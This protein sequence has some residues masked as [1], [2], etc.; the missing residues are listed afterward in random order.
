MEIDINQRFPKSTC[1]TRWFSAGK[2]ET[3]TFTD[4]DIPPISELLPHD[5][6][7]ILLDRV[8]CWNPKRLVAEVD[9][10]RR[11]LFSD[12]QGLTPSWL[13][14]EY[15]VQAMGALA[16]LKLIQE[17]EDVKIGFLLGVRNFK[18][19][20]AKFPNEGKLL[21]EVNEVLLDPETNLA[22]FDGTITQ[23]GTILCEGQIKAVMPEDPHQLLEK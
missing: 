5:P 14:I 9:C 18:A 4:M 16:G 15:L 19:M 8:V 11:N 6:P 3:N 23:D 13:G 7:M 21:V 10:T 20:H 2:A 22:A 1:K 12:E 17:G